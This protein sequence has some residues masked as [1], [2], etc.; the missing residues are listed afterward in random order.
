VRLFAGIPIPPD[1]TANV[2][3]LLDT[4]RPSAQ[5]RWTPV[6]NLHIT[7][8][9]IGEWPETRVPEIVESLQPLRERPPVSVS[10]SGLGWFPNP[11]SPRILFAAVH[12]SGAL[13]SLAAD[14]DA[15][16]EPLGIEREPKPFRPHLTLARIKDPGAPLAGLRQAIAQ[17]DDTEFGAFPVSG[18][19]LY[20][21]KPG[22]AGS[23][24][25]RLADIR[26]AQ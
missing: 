13:S 26:F 19:S 23:I 22:P 11:H 14:T 25:T 16:L 3:R 5:I 21:S 7:T 15:A 1:V 6:Y 4:L 24:Y 10:I 20:L 18:F 9:F 12:D 2:S 8:R 17:L